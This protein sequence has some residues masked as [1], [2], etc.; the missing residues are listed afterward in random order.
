MVRVSRL[1]TFNFVSVLGSAASRALTDCALALEL[2]DDGVEVASMAPPGS[3]LPALLYPEEPDERLTAQARRISVSNLRCRFSS[4]VRAKAGDPEPE[5]FS[6]SEGNLRLRT[7][8]L[9]APL[10]EGHLEPCLALLGP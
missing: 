2:E 9:A 7:S 6:S 1:L 8:S 5:S 4:L 10:E 3:R